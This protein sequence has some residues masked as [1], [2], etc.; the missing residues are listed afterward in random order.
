M[1]DKWLH[2]IRRMSLSQLEALRVLVKKEI[3]EADEV[4]IGLEG[5]ALG[6]VFSSLSRCRIGDESL[7][8]PWGRGVSRGLRWK[9]NEKVVDKKRLKEV[10]N[11]ILNV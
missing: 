10:I 6:G 3:I 7:V 5:K 9:L 4:K 8:V 1:V 11:E 2:K